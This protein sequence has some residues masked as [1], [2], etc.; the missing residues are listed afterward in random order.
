MLS[1]SDQYH[2]GSTVITDSPNTMIRDNHV[3]IEEGGGMGHPQD[4]AEGAHSKHR[5]FP[6]AGVEGEEHSSLQ[7]VG[8]DQDSFALKWGTTCCSVPLFSIKLTVVLLFGSFCI[9][10]VE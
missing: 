3:S 6:L 9:V 2:M 10:V 8:F 7:S 4:W 5:M 1:I